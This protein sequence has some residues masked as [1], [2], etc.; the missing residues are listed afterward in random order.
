VDELIEK[1]NMSQTE[2]QRQLQ[3]YQD[4][5][6]NALVLVVKVEP[7]FAGQDPFI[8]RKRFPKE[9]KEA[10][11]SAFKE[12]IINDDTGLSVGMSGRNFHKHLDTTG[13]IDEL[14]HLEA[15]AALPTLMRVAKRIKIHNDKDPQPMLENVHRFISAF[16]DGTGDYAVLLTVKEYE[17]GKYILDKENPVKLYHHR[18][19]K[20]LT[21]APSAASVVDS[22]P[23]LTPSSANVYTIRQLLE[24][25]KDSQGKIY[26]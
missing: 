11:L 12:V 10:V 14:I 5:D 15:I 25:V 17:T 13:S 9:V 2:Q 8:L 22:D 7:H 21:P 16:S 4:V 6:L 23:S 18:V 1:L 3:F 26:F 20:Q 24:G 19:E